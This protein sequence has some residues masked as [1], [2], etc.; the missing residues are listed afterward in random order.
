MAVKQSVQNEVVVVQESK[1]ALFGRKRAELAEVGIDLDSI[2]ETY[3]YFREMQKE[4]PELKIPTYRAK[5]PPGGGKIFEILTGD[6]EFD[7]TVK[8]IR[9]VVAN[10]HN[11]N[12]L[13]TNPEST[14]EPPVCSSPDGIKGFLLFI[15]IT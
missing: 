13:F 7:F 1:L 11:C 9:G 12:A 6:D 8:S 10:F 15:I 14:K 3:E 5:I 4:D 2:V